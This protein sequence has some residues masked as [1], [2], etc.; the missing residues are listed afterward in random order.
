MRQD[1]CNGQG[2]AQVHCSNVLDRGHVGDRDARPRTGQDKDPGRLSSY[3]GRRRTDMAGR[4]RR[5]LLTLHRSGLSPHTPCRSPGALTRVTA[6]T[7]ALSP[8]IVT[9]YPE[10]SA[11]SLSPCL[12]RLLPAGAVAGWDLHPL[13]SAV[14]ARRTPGADIAQPIALRL[15]CV[16]SRRGPVM[17]CCF[18]W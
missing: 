4:G 5:G 18:P 8:Y 6:C 12:L 1:D 15:G 9:R 10:A 14:F 11:I 13:E 17:T 2:A 16:P 3:A 7:L